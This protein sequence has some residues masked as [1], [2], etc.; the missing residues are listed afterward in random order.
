M[1]TIRVRESGVRAADLEA[2]RAA[3]I[4]FAAE[5]YRPLVRGDQRAK[6]EQYVRGLLLEGRR[7]SIQP[8]AARLADGDE[9]GLQNFITDSP[10]DDEP[11]RRRLARRMTAEIEPEGWIVDDTGLPKDG[12]FSPGVA[13][14]YCGALGKTANCQVLVSVN[15]ASDLASCPLQWRL[16][17]PKSWDQDDERRR[18]ARIPDEVRHVPKWQLAL[19]IIDQLLEWGLERRV[20]QA[21]GGYGDTTAFRVGLEE[22]ELEYAVQVKGSQTSAQP[23][24]AVPV[25][26]AYQGR[27]RPPVARYPEKP[28][29]LR[30]LVMSAGREQVRTV[31]WRE[32]DRGPLAS[33]FIALRVRP[34]NDAQRDQDGVLPERWMLAE[35]PEDKDE[36]IKYWLSNLPPET[37]LVTLVRL[38]KLRWRVEHDYRELKQ[39]LGLD[40]YEGR[41]FCGLHHHLTCVTVAHAFLTC[42]R[43]TRGDPTAARP[44]PAAA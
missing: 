4:E 37:P 20:V 24:D 32:G 39:C 33:Q 7:K 16:F 41:T 1:A 21:D 15:A 17:V 14:Q 42:C 3:L 11:V 6:G 22:R 19:E 35:W 8:M 44:Q 38:A 13:H 27:G 18:R 43:L 12:R 31:S 9:E 28:S 30:D 34:A 26:P 36:P 23:P 2:Q 40:H 29:C 10:W 25:A 5:M